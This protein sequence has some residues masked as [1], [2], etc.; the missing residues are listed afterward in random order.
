M[1]IEDRIKILAFIIEFIG[2][3]PFIKLV[4]SI[5]VENIHF[6]EKAFKNKKTG[7]VVFGAGNN[8]VFSKITLT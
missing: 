3:I 2:L 4:Y 7:V 5:F 8:N 6:H 1:K